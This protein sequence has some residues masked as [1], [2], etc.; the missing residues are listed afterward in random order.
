M[1][2]ACLTGRKII[3]DIYGGWRAHGGGAFSKKVN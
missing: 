2:D 1:G 3:V